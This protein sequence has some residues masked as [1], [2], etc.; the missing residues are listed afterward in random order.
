MSKSDLEAALALHLRAN[1]FPPWEAEYRFHPK[2]RW[3][4]DM[5]W[6]EQRIAVEVHGGIHMARGGHNTAAGITR[7]CEKGNEALIL[8]WRVLAVTADQIHDG[9]AVDWLRRLMFEQGAEVAPW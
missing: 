5:A 7:D 1:D 2:R 9:S 8:G 6:P 3:R 4:L